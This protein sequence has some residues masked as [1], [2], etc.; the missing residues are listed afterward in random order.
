VERISIYASFARYP[1]RLSGFKY[2]A[3]CTSID[4][5]SYYL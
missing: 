3:G 4:Y 5:F 1:N 2:L